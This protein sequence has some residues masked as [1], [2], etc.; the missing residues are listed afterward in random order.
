M[1]NP[2][3]G[4][5]QDRLIKRCVSTGI[6]RPDQYHAYAIHFLKQMNTSFVGYIYTLLV[7]PVFLPGED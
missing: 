5:V 2:H 1:S 3:F 7:L 4:Q 6:G